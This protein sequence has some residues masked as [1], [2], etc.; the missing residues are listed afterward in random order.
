M[1]LKP[2]SQASPSPSKMALLSVAFPAL[3]L[4]PLGVSFALDQVQALPSLQPFSF[5]LS[6]FQT[7]ISS[8]L[9]VR[10]RF[11]LSSSER[12]RVALLSA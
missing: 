10:L 12:F 2:S 5:L 8:L 11:R 7:L 1:D 4:F 9:R 3:D 6:S